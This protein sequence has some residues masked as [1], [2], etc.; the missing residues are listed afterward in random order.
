MSIELLPIVVIEETDGD[1]SPEAPRACC[2]SAARKR[3]AVRTS[4]AGLSIVGVLGWLALPK[5]PMC[6]AVYIAMGSGLS[7]TLAQS[8]IL[9]SA[10]A[11]LAAVAF[12][13][14]T[15]RLALAIRRHLTPKVG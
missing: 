1:A 12:L 11:I 2:C 10:L 6:L 8:R 9:Y 4:D 5:C 13:I 14:G 7:L 15:V 3:S